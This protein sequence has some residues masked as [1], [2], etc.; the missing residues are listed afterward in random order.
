[1]VRVEHVNWTVA[2]G[3]FW[4]IGGLH[5]S[6]KG[7]LLSLT[8][9]LMPPMRG[10]YPFLWTQDANLR[11]EVHPRTPASWIGFSNRSTAA[12]SLSGGERRITVRYHH[13][14]LPDAEIDKRVVGT[15]EW[16]GLTSWGDAMPGMLSRSWQKRVGLARALM[17]DPEVLLLDMPLGGLDPRH[18]NWWLNFLNNLSSGHGRLNGRKI[19]VVLTAEDFRPW[20]NPACQFAIVENQHFMKVGKKQDLAGCGGLRVVGDCWRRKSST[21]DENSLCRFKT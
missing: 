9:G 13:G 7:D 8:A 1:M 20:D 6:G 5:G 14:N 21:R 2:P 11:R 16:T 19:T 4:V 15:L 3:D 17:Q 12:S 10:T 18:T